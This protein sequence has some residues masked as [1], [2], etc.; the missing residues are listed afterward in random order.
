MK[1]FIS[2]IVG[3]AV[4]LSV[5]AMLRRSKRRDKACYRIVE[6]GDALLGDD[7]PVSITNIRLTIAEEA[8]RKQLRSLTFRLDN[9]S[10]KPIGY[11]AI[12]AGFDSD[13]SIVI[14]IGRPIAPGETIEYSKTTGL[15]ESGES[16]SLAIQELRFVKG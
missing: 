13:A 4:V 14:E 2:I 7:S 12:S 16:V 1:V 9:K 10:D 8:G 5:L 11:L 6:K 3:V 15:P